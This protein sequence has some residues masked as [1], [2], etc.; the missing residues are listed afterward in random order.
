MNKGKFVSQHMIYLKNF[1]NFCACAY[2]L[3]LSALTNSILQKQYS[4]FAQV[5]IY[6]PPTPIILNL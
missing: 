5:N 4:L 2:E 1:R 6:G 3:H